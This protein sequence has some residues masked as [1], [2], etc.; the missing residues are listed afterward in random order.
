MNALS[1]GL[2]AALSSAGIFGMPA[3]A[4]PVSNLTMATNDVSPRVENVGWGPN[5]YAPGYVPPGIY[6]GDG[7]GWYGQG[8][9][10]YGQG[11]NRYGDWMALYGGWYRGRWYGGWYTPGSWRYRRDW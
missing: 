7:P 1:R 2:V 9:G 8:Q 6:Y 5:Y 10:W 3:V 11:R 4:M